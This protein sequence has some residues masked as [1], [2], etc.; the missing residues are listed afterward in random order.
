MS[1][2]RDQI[3]SYIE[4]CVKYCKILYTIRVFDILLCCENIDG[5]LSATLNYEIWTSRDLPSTSFSR[6]WTDQ[7]R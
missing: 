6:V 2:G 1:V 4:Q 3:R 7:G 5:N